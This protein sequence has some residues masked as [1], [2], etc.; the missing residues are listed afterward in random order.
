MSLVKPNVYDGPVQRQVNLGDVVGGAEQI[1][2]TSA[3]NALTVTG[4]MLA[5][6]FIQ[7]TE[8]AN[9]TYTLDTAANILAALNNGLG[10]IGIQPGTTFRLRHINNAAFTVTYA[11]TANTGTSVALPVVNA[12]SVKDFLLT[13][14]NGTAAQTFA[15]TT[16]NGNNVVG[17]F[18][19]AQLSLLTTGMIITSA[20]AG[21][22]GT[23]ITSINITGGTIT[24]LANAT[25]TNV[26]PIAFTFSPVIS[27]SGIGQG[28]L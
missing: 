23:T 4:A 11:S 14:V 15:A 19:S 12:S 18:T 17:G 3:S 9:A 10:N 26:T 6:S 5:S 13:I 25:S 16:T 7:S 2:A 24:T 21:L 27:L 20:S 8:T 22:Q 1:P 28:L